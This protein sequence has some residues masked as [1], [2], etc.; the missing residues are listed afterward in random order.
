[1][2]RCEVVYRDLEGVEHRVEVDADSLYEAI[3]AAVS[4]FR[5]G[6]WT[7]CPPGPGCIFN[8]R[9]FPDRPQVYSVAL[10]QVESFARHGTVK[11][12]KDI[13]R[14]QK[15]QEMLGLKG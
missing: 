8:V 13:L 5:K 3:A 11:G 7:R 1:V 12:P 2:T 6:L 15:I 9:V 10:S 14:K 4:S